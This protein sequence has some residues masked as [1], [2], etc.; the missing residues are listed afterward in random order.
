MRISF[1]WTA[2]AVVAVIQS[3]AAQTYTECN[4]LE[5]TCDPNDGLATYRFSTN[6]TTGDSAFDGWTTTS[7]TVTSTDLGALFTI[8]EQGDAPTIETKFYIFFG[9]I[10]ARFR[11]ASGTGI[12][13]TAILESDDLDEIDWEQVSTFDNQIQTNYFGKGNTTSYDRAITVSVS[14]PEETFHTYSISWT[15]SATQWFVDGTLVRTLNY[16]D[17]VGGKNYPQTPMRVRIGI[18]AGGDPSNSPG[19]IEWA[20][21]ET[22][23]TQGPFSMYLESVRI[24]NYNPAEEYTYTDRTGS[25]T[26]ISASNATSEDETEGEGQSSSI[27]VIP[28]TTR[29]APSS[30][31]TVSVTVTPSVCPTSSA[32]PTPSYTPVYGLGVS[33]RGSAAGMSSILGIVAIVIAG[34]VLF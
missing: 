25:Y 16:A 28:T 11:A 29:V 31:V 21:G 20:G 12:V 23:Y 13:S 27:P 5:E 3:C 7:G 30:S 10:E 26:S 14:S 8:N 32:V 33:V 15:E 24:V 18:W 6:F 9:Y 34:K 2:I 4:P 22:D 1:K 19:T 17:A